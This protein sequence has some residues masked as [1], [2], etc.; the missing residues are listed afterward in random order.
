MKGILEP[1]SRKASNSDQMP[2]PGTPAT[3][4]TP[5][6]FSDRATICPPVSFITTSFRPSTAG[7]AH[8][9]Y[10]GGLIPFKETLAARVIAPTDRSFTHSLLSSNHR[11]ERSTRH[12]VAI[13][14]L[15]APSGPRS[16]P[17]GKDGSNTVQ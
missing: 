12:T 17:S 9:N 15:P 10:R 1:S 4:S 8:L 16:L 2:C 13:A 3:Y 11:K 14:D 5:Y 6:S 7:T